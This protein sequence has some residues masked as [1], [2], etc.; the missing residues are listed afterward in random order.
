MM[1]E[2]L[3]LQLDMV[4]QRTFQQLEGITE[5]TADITPHGYRNT[6]RWNLGHILTVQ[7][8]LCFKLAGHPFE[9][10]ETYP[11]FF[12]SGTKPADWQTEPPSLETLK[13]QLTE[14]SL[15]IKQKLS[16][17]LDEKPP[18]P[19][20]GID[21]VGGMITFSLYHEGLHTGYM[22]AMRK[23]LQSS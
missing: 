7:E 13:A 18:A 21:T 22:M 11:D 20:R 17:R 8:N 4:R 12:A 6:M 16:E 2:D 15:R 10:P 3:F 9:L 5:E 1:K 23:T 14:Q 19:F